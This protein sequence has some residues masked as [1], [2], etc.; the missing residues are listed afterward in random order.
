MKIKNTEGFR[1]W[2]KNLV[3]ARKILGENFMECN[4]IRSQVSLICIMEIKK[5]FTAF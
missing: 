2:F 4:M 5:I 1:S 3:E